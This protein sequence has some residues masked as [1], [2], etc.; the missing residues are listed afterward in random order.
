M[1]LV[2]SSVQQKDPGGAWHTELD[3]EEEGVVAGGGEGGEPQLSLEATG[4]V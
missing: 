3:V 1:G 2:G 4:N